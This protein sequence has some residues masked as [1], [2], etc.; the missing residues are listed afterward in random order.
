MIVPDE[1]L[2]RLAGA[3]SL[4]VGLDF[5]G[6]LAEIAPR[7]EQ[8]RPVAGVIPVMRRLLELEGV[9]VAAVSGRPR[10][11]LVERLSP[12]DG[13]I[14]IGEHGADAGDP[15]LPAPADYAAVRTV[16]EAVAERYDGA[17][18]EQ[19]KVG[20]AIHGRALDAEP[21][22]RMAEEAERALEPIASGRYE[23][24]NRVVEVRLTG[25]TKGAAILTLRAP[26]EVVLY[27][28]DDTTDETVFAVLGTDDV[29]V[30]VG[31]GETAARYRLPDPPAVV[32]FLRDLVAR[33]AE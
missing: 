15:D 28:G 32:A 31:P 9:R 16:L 21:A 24:G 20:L 14:L 7:P 17:W 26:G 8:A 5:D 22:L 29:G 11:D 25:A 12:P 30:K 10:D 13:V 19:K 18:V 23:R 1:A 3:E 2:D 6:V 27:V 4:L 33:R